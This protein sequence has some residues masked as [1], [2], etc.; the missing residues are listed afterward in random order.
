MRFI[1]YYQ[2]NL[3]GKLDV[4]LGSSNYVR[5]YVRWKMEYANVS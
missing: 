3:D 2:E 5:Y 4:V 1:E